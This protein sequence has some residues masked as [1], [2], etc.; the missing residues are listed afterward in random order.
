MKH[1]GFAA[2][3]S[4]NIRM[5]VWLKVL[6]NACFNPVSLLTGS[7]TDRMIDDPGL[8]R[9]FTGMMQEVL[10]LG[11]AI[12]VPVD[13]EPG[14]RLALTRK[15]GNIKTSMLQD[16]EANRAVEVEGIIGTLVEIAGQI[17]FQAPLLETV[18]ALARMRSRVLGLLP[19]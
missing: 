1:A 18:C 10:A 7:P 4:D 8:Y 16:V 13:I 12:G 9:L 3:A 14:P 15:L 17:E 6:G 11:A 19:E 2:E 5:E